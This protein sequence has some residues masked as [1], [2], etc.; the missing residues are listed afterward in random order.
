MPDDAYEV[1]LGR[2][3]V[4]REGTDVTVIATGHLVIDA[5]AAA[6]DLDQRGV[7][8]E[9]VDPR[10]LSPL[11]TE[12]IITSVQKT[13]RAVVAHE[14]VRFCGFGAEVAAQIA[15][16]AVDSL[17]APVLRVGAPFSPVPYSPSLEEVWLPGARQI[18]GAVEQIVPGAGR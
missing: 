15:E 12:T 13:G 7:S 3:D 18:V 5:L 10:T 17:D 1:P 6:E 11:D 4:K 16:H 8:V 2:A 14:A 9:V